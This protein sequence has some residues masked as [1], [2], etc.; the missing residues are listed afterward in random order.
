MVELADIFRIH[1]QQYQAKFKDRM[2]P[3]H[4][5]VMQDIEMC[6]TESLGGQVYF[7]KECQDY[8]YSYHSCKNRHC[9]K[10]QN[11]NAQKWLERQYELLL[12]VTHFMNTFTLPDSLRQ[13]ARSN[14]KTIYNILFKTS[15]AALQKLALDLKIYW[16]ENRHGWCASYMDKGQDVSSAHPLYHTQRR[17]LCR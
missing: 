3:S 8:H 7:C 16:R 13:L 9:P 10:C 17:S 2:L 12:P 1:G 5:K 6:R 4:L 14:Q 11:D 15:A